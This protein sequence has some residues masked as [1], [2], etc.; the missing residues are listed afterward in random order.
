MHPRQGGRGATTC[1]PPRALATPAGLRGHDTRWPRRARIWLAGV[2]VVREGRWELGGRRHPRRR[3]P[4]YRG[5]VRGARRRV[6]SGRA[7]PEAGVHVV[8]W[9]L[10]EVTLAA[11]HGPVPPAAR[12]VGRPR[13]RPRTGVVVV[14]RIQTPTGRP[15]EAAE[16]STAQPAGP[17]TSTH[18]CRACPALCCACPCCAVLVPCRCRCHSTS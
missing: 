10:G 12:T 13:T 5:S 18:S 6:R 4:L 3:Q 16:H 9:V 2:W 1:P 7:G 11:T 15:A 14:S 17:P 8:L